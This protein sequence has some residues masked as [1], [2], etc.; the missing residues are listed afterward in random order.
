MK[1]IGIETA[2]EETIL[3]WV[4]LYPKFENVEYVGELANGE[5]FLSLLESLPHFKFIEPKY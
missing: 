5:F 2:V 1:S 4:K 3:G